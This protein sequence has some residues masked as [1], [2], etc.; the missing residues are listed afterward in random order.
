MCI[1]WATYVAGSMQKHVD[2]SK[3]FVFCA[4]HAG[5]VPVMLRKARRRTGSQAYWPN[6]A[7]P[8]PPERCIGGPLSRISTRTGDLPH[9]PPR[10]APSRRHLQAERASGPEVKAQAAKTACR[11]ALARRRLSSRSG[12]SG[13]VRPTRGLP[14]LG[15]RDRGP[16]GSFGPLRVAAARPRAPPPPRTRDARAQSRRASVSTAPGHDVAR[17]RS[18]S[19][20]AIYATSGPSHSPRLARPAGAP[21]TVARARYRR[22]TCNRES[23]GPARESRF[24]KSSRSQAI[25]L[26]ISVRTD[27]NVDKADHCRTNC[28]KGETAG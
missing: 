10:G 21:A 9:A 18:P 4:V 26:P 25:G 2:H 6:K 28:A 11:C 17:A 16:A 5:G 13:P 3:Q 24:V 22:T 27:F 23:G 12:P 15:E 1:Q 14:S 7:P 8:P 20:G 19:A